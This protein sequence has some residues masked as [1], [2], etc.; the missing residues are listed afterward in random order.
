MLRAAGI[1]SPVIREMVEMAYEFEQPYLVDGSKFA[2]A[3]AD[4]GFAPTSHREALAATIAWYRAHATG[5]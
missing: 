4:S 1:F 5:T 3:F 2:R